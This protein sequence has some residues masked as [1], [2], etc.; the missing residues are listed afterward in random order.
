VTGGRG[1]RELLRALP[2]F[3]SLGE[4]SLQAMAK[5]TVTRRVRPNEVLF[6]R[7]EPCDAL[8]VVVSGSVQVYRAN[9]DG[10][11]QVLHVQ[12]PGQPLAEVTLR[13]GGSFTLAGTQ[14]KV[15]RTLATTRE[16]VA[17][18]LGELRRSGTIAQS[19]A[20]IRVLDVARLAARAR[21]EA[22]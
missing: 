4:G 17:R 15:A 16:G 21:G 3:A 5:R 11:V 10:R 2:L 13:D 18:A 19:G 9:A 7:G 8:Y 22:A 12:G 6:R 20:R 1:T 14:E